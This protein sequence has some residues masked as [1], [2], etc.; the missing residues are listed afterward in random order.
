[1]IDMQVFWLA[2]IQ[3]LTEFLPVSSSGHL[4]LFSKYTS[5]ADQGQVI[6]I[7]LHIGSLIAVV[8]Y[9]GKTIQQML[10]DLFKEKFLYE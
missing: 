3:G 10:V 6:D 1:M 2:L 9:F 5:F 7:A 8:L 4:I